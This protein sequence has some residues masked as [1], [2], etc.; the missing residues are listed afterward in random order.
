MPNFYNLQDVGEKK[1]FIYEAYDVIKKAIDKSEK[2]C[3]NAHKWYG[4]ILNYIGEFE[5]Y[6]QQ[7]LNSYEI[8]KHFEKALAINDKDPTTW[9]LLGVWHF[10]C[11]DLSY[12]LRLIAKTIFGTPPLSTFES[13]LE[14]F[15]KA[16]SPNFYSRNTWYL[17]EVYER[18]GRYDEAKAFY[19]AAF[20]M[21]II[22]ID[23]IE[24]H[25]MVDLKY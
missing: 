22:T 16:E 5:G 4:I 1:R 17:A 2:D 6:R 12:P 24:V 18:L 19:L 7:I 20:K 25:R 21:P 9:H 3:A 13:A 10:A 15:E 23:D 8:R 14:Y 11:A